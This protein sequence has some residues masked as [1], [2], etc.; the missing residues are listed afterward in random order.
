M[1]ANI[2][3]SSYL[4]KALQ[5]PQRKQPVWTELG[6]WGGEHSEDSRAQH[7]HTQKDAPPI[8]T[9]KVAPWDLCAQVAEEESAE[10][11]ALSLQVPRILRDLGQDD[12]KR[13]WGDK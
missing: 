3:A 2:Q 8:V 11:P 10:Q 12:G 1:S 5:R 4:S 6:S 7:T 13:E 9:G